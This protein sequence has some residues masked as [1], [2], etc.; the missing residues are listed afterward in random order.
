MSVSCRTSGEGG[1]GVKVWLLAMADEGVSGSCF[2][3]ER[4]E[5][6]VGEPGKR[7]SEGEDEAGLAYIYM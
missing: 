6:G 4:G 1:G 5:E 2:S 7:G 3:Q